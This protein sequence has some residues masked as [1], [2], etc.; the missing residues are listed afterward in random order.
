M[1]GTVNQKLLLA[2]V[3]LCSLLLA[4]CGDDS[5]SGGSG[6]SGG[7]TG[8]SGGE[9]AAG[10]GNT[11]GSGGGAQVELPV[12]E[13]CEAPTVHA[14]SSWTPAAGQRFA[15]PQLAAQ[16]TGAALAYAESIGEDSWELKL[17]ALT[18]SGQKSGAPMVLGTS[19]A[20][21]APNVT[22]A[23]AASGFVVCWDSTVAA[24]TELAC[25]A[26]AAGA[27]E[28]TAGLTREG[29]HPALAFG[30]AG[31]GLLYGAGNA[32]YSQLLDEG[33]AAVGAEQEVAH[34]SG[35]T[36]ADPVA[37]GMSS[38]YVAVAADWTGI[39]WRFDPTFTELEGET[40][41]GW[42]KRPTSLAGTGTL[43]GAA[44]PDPANG[45]TFKR[46]D[47]NDGVVGPT[48]VDDEAASSIYRF[49][50]V[51]RGGS[52]TFAVVWSAFEGHVGYRAIGADGSARG[53][54]IEVL[55]T[56]WDDNPV[57]IVGVS[58]GFL[59]ASAI[60][61]GYDELVVVHLACR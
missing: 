7:A 55:M 25:S 30:P 54:P 57:S 33:A 42:A 36:S 6:G 3:S 29:S 11:G 39:L 34:S 58:D 53:Q 10:G 24:T 37:A 46:V 8:G 1:I 45:V 61:P 2:A 52:E 35:R 60:N 41:A 13:A 21:L 40:Q 44:W 4:G 22:I 50:A 5:S 20:A 26:V 49:T 23:A 17:Q 59:V 9:G 47:A 18:P 19:S 56:H 43:V 32:L 31:V 15:S 48:R 16:A 38:G 14:G 51:A 28:A 27:S 12:S